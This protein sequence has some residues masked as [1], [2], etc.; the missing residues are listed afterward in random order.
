MK[1][2]RWL[3]HEP[4]PGQGSPADPLDDLRTKANAISVFLIPKPDVGVSAHRV[5]AASAAK[6]ETL[7]HFEYV[8]FDASALDTIAAT[9]SKVSGETPDAGVNEWH[10]NLTDM[11]AQQLAD[12]ADVIWAV[13]TE[14]VRLYKPDVADLI[15][16]GIRVGQIDRTKVTPR[17]L[18]LV[19][20]DL[21]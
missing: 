2:T 11:S 14:I 8:L 5:A 20:G 17:I 18:D 3:D 4:W 9:L 13:R 12:V 7:D 10:Q 16:E 21:K 19:E 6:R 1:R 15:V